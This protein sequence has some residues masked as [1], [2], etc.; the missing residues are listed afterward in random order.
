MVMSGSVIKILALLSM[1]EEMDIQEK[2]HINIRFE[3]C[4]IVE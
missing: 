2:M 3:S 1:C 4:A